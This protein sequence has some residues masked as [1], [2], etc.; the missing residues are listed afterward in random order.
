MEEES[1]DE[2]GNVFRSSFA[3]VLIWNRRNVILLAV[4]VCTL[5]LALFFKMAKTRIREIMFFSKNW[6]NRQTLDTL[7]VIR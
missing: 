4:S 7:N 1:E 6:G 5:T 2:R 3:M